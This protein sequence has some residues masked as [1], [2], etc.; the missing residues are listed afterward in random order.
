MKL[1]R[2]ILACG[3]L[4]LVSSAFI[5]SASSQ[6]ESFQQT[7]LPD[8]TAPKSGD[9]TA[10]SVSEQLQPGIVVE[11]VEKYS[12]GEKAGLREGDLLLN[13]SRGDAQGT[14]QSP[15]DFEMVRIEQ[16]PRGTVTLEGCRGKEKRTWAFAPVNIFLDSGI[17]AR[18]NF[19]QNSLAFYMKARTLAR[20]GKL[21]QA[22]E[23]WKKTIIH[24]Q[25]S[26]PWLSAWFS[27][28]SAT[29]FSSQQQWNKADLAFQAAVEEAKTAGPVVESHVLQ[30]WGVS[31]RQRNDISNAEERYQ[32]ALLES[33]R[34]K[35]ENMFAASTLMALGA[36]FTYTDLIKAKT[37]DDAALAMRERLAPESLSVSFSLHALG[38]NAW[39]RGDLRDAEDLNR[40]ALAIQQ[41]FPS[42]SVAMSYHDLGLIAR[43][44]GDLMTAEKYYRKAL[45]IEQRS[46]SDNAG[47]ANTLD[48]LGDVE[49]Q[50]GSG[51][52][53]LRYHRQALAVLKKENPYDFSYLY[54]FYRA[55]TL[56]SLGELAEEHGDWTKA[57]K[58]YQKSLNLRE[59]QLPSCIDAGRT[60]NHL[61][62]V[63]RK[64]GQLAKSQKYYRRALAAFH[65]L[66]APVA[67][68]AKSTV[69][70]AEIARRKHQPVLA[71]KFYEQALKTFE[72][73]T[74]RLG[75]SE[76]TQS[77]F[78]AQYSDYYKD[79]AD[80]LITQKKSNI[81]FQVLERLRARSLLE[82][83]QADHAEIRKGV[84]PTLV[85]KERSL[86]DW[87]NAK[88][89]RRME[90]PADKN[91]DEQVAAFDK[92][93]NDLLA[94]Y[95]DVE[96]QIRTTS[97]AYAALT[98]PQP[99]TAKEVQERLL[100]PDTLLL[101]YLLGEERSYVFA[102]TPDFLNAYEL[103]KRAV[104]EP[105][106][107]RA[108]KLLSQ[109]SHQSQSPQ[110][111]MLATK[112]EAEYSCTITELSRMILGPVSRQLQQKRLLIVS[113]GALQYIPFSALQ[114]PDSLDSA[115]P[116]PLV[117]EHEIINL[118]SASV[119]AVLRREEIKRK[120]ATNEVA[121]MA[122]P[123]FGPRDERVT[124]SAANGQA[125]T[126]KPAA[127][128]SSDT[129]DLP[130]EPETQSDLD[131]S[132][133]QLGISGFPRLPFTR[134]EAEAIYSIAGKNALEALDFDAS[135]ATALGAQLRD[136]R[137]VHFATHGLLNN[138]HPELSGLVL[139]LVDKQGNEQDG[140][141]RMLD[142]YNM[143]LN[144][145][146]VVLSACQTA[147]GKELGEEGLV[148]L[149]RGFMYAGAPR[150]VASLWKVD[151][152]AT[153]EL[154]KKFYEGMLRDHQTPAQAL[155]SAQQWMRMQKPWQSPYYWAGFELQGEWK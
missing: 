117:A 76:E 87:I 80:L 22:D 57:A 78:R 61:G 112:A 5:F 26:A 19:S 100:A 88:S 51:V 59:R 68:E 14:F 82:T 89:N 74:T 113:D 50:R 56:E 4:L 101:E 62:D 126:N 103:P 47:L 124:L 36:L 45:T 119:L 6:T 115:K 52:A 58:Y 34:C 84:D 130:V 60:L 122:D 83:L 140:F 42:D 150:V 69:G 136:Y 99:I 149:T 54:A 13:W 72:S 15:F 134:R 21:K 30:A 106:A 97:P 18:P 11:K 17:E 77:S 3:V 70:L 94:Q 107:R 90:L 135:K 20:E 63:A 12:N 65:K 8:Q 27:L 139:S 37:Y 2:S 16:L 41:R 10:E 25:S 31:F 138:D 75:G 38:V 49:R 102:I 43:S 9:V 23:Y 39:E 66:N 120:P 141:L 7:K 32:Q 55:N 48:G 93:I 144:A 53:A 147:L 118:P 132:A 151:D 44:R 64:S 116:T 129:F 104:I 1:R 110:Q 137:I 95:K 152:E 79:Y 28:H 146:L 127:Q 24:T 125:V 121:V 133:Q 98:Q 73:Q 96:E 67:E 131:R 91:S 111:R 29:Q 40:R 143:D 108:Y 153:A 33:E 46:M 92:E 145:D 142:I 105:L 148:G 109:H 35:P 81:A 114:R 86:Q 154:M 128:H 155:R 71:S 123:V 85:E